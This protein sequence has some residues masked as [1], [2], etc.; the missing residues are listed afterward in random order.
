M[1]NSLNREVGTVFDTYIYEVGI[2]GSKV[3]AGLSSFSYSATVGLFRS[4]VSLF[5]VLGTNRLAK[6]VGEEG[7]Y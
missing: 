4:V 3:P 1:V 6:A 7:I 2:L 5:L